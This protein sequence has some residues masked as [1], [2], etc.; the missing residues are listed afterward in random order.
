MSF[1]WPETGERVRG[2]YLGRDFEGVVLS[3]G[4]EQA[5]LGRRYT[6]KFDAPVE[7]SRSALMS[8]PRQRVSALVN[9]AGASIDGKGRQDG[10]MTLARA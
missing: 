10:I 9:D 2:T 7:V 8:I 4:F 5:S 1:E 3:V 6:I